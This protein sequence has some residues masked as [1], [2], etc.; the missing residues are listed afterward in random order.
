MFCFVLCRPPHCQFGTFLS[1]TEKFRASA[2]PQASRNYRQSGGR[3][4][5]ILEWN[6][7]SRWQCKNFLTQKNALRMGLKFYD[8]D[9][10]YYAIDVTAVSHFRNHRKTRLVALHDNCAGGRGILNQR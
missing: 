7:N 3:G 10:L 2:P 1:G 6:R 9:E 8:E 5:A 4:G